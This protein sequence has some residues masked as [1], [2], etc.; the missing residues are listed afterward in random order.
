MR[1]LRAESTLVATYPRTVDGTG[2][3][4]GAGSSWPADGAD[5]L[6]ITAPIPVVLGAGPQHS[7]A[8]G[9]H[10]ELTNAAQSTPGRVGSDVTD[11]IPE[12]SP[13]DH[14]RRRAMMSALGV[15]VAALALVA[16]IGVVVTDHSTPAVAGSPTSPPGPSSGAP[17]GSGSVVI[18]GASS[19]APLPASQ[20]TLVLGDSL[21]LVVYP[22]LA[23]A[24]PDRYV[25]YA[26]EVGRSTAHTADALDAL[27]EIPPVVIV[28]SGTN[29]QRASDF[30]PSVTRILDKLGPSRC[31]VWVDVVRPDRVGDPQATMNAALGDVVAGHPNVRVLKWSEMV[32]GHPEWMA[33][34]GIHPNQAGAQA[35]AAAFAEAATGCSPLDSTAPR[36]PRQTLPDSIFW[37]PI[38][39]SNHVGGPSGNGSA[40]PSGQAS[41]H[42]PKASASSP[43]T[44]PDPSASTHSPTPTVSSPPSAS[45]TSS[46][47]STSPPPPPPATTPPSTPTGAASATA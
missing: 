39:G 1:T 31:V 47:P 28:S 27:A 10:D 4:A 2:E 43:S 17:S 36:A 40:Q 5:P 32:A 14:A 45:S 9:L 29:D 34:D 3:D 8:S 30:T 13:T 6:E 20:P 18:S 15:T 12:P 24:L 11:V 44:T 37:G 19:T 33:G 23:D 38:S 41:S 35:R 26:A 7:S 46:S 22:W 16:G 21:G 25:S 42:S